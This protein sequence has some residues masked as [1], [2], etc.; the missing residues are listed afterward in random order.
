MNAINIRLKIQRKRR[1]LGCDLMRWRQE[2]E[3]QYAVYSQDHN[4]PI[5]VLHESTRPVRET[6]RMR[7]FKDDL[8]LSI[9][10][11]VFDERN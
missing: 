2:G 7:F 10:Q 11:A 8:E 1:C 3:R 4:L 9:Q 5:L 6:H